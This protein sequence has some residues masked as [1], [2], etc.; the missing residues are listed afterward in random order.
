MGVLFGGG[1]VRLLCS[2]PQI[3]KQ[4][5]KQGANFLHIILSGK[6]KASSVEYNKNIVKQNTN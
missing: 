5:N 1:G 3:N 4:I 6:Y 2:G